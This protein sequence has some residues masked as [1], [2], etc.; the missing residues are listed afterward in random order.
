M[1]L[2]TERVA[3]VLWKQMHGLICVYKPPDIT[4]GRLV[5]NLRLIIPAGLNK[6]IVRQPRKVIRYD[7]TVGMPVETIETDYSDHPLVIGPR[8]EPSE[9][10]YFCA[11]ALTLHGGG[12]CMVGLNGGR[13]LAKD[14]ESSKP[15]RVYRL[16][17]Q[18][19]LATDNLHKSGKVVERTTFHKVHRSIIDSV[20]A[21]MQS[22][23]QR[24]MY[25]NSGVNI[26]SQ[27]AYDLAVKGLLRPADDS[28]PII[29][30]IKCVDFTRPFFTIEVACINER[31]DQ[32]MGLI[33]TIGLKVKSAARCNSIK[34]I[35]YGPFTLEHA[36]LQHQWKV[37][38]IAS[39]IQ[40]CN[41]INEEDI[42]S[43]R[44]ENIDLVPMEMNREEKWENEDREDWNQPLSSAVRGPAN[45]RERRRLNHLESRNQINGQLHSGNEE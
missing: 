18:L 41:A 22:S 10:R 32:L 11:S 12:V 40:M 7:A 15:V 5:Q 9:I 35:R 45:Q 28:F 36:L 21:A 42:K 27:T 1:A 23:H 20:V 38:K 16:V 19:G 33:H 6:M 3:S 30:N 4:L 31:E 2:S 34:C 14:L 26:Q 39:N 13:H 29:Y 25:H 37:D 8:Y 44:R 24:H 17:G 43:G